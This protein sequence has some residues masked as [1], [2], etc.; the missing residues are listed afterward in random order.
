MTVTQKVE[1][2][3]TLHA[4]DQLK[5]NVSM[6]VDGLSLSEPIYQVEVLSGAGC[7]LQVSSLEYEYTPD[8]MFGMMAKQVREE[9][10]KG[11]VAKAQE[12]GGIMTVKEIQDYLDKQAFIRKL[13]SK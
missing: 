13:K 8:S 4:G 1:G 9:M 2:S 6:Q 5:L 11:L 12:L 7:T 10:N 3:Y